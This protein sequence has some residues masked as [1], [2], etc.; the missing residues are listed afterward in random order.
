MIK[1]WHNVAVRGRFMHDGSLRTLEEV[2]EHYNSGIQGNPN[3]DLHLVDVS[4]KAPVKMGLT[5]LEKSQLK[6]FL[7]TLTDQTF[8]T[9]PKFSDPFR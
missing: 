3:L 2:I 4:T 9:D 8:I 1:V 7:E 5:E 6:A